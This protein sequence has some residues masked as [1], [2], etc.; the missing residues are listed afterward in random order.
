MEF[1][2][3]HNVQEGLIIKIVDRMNALNKIIAEDNKNLGPGYRI[4]HSYFCPTDNE[5]TYDDKWYHDVI[6]SE[7]EPLLKEYWFDNPEKVS[8][9]IKELKA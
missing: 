6:K 9:C 7:I 2:K 1:L 3:N 4:G 5:Q 8:N